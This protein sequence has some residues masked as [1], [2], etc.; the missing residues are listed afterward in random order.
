[1]PAAA[2]RPRTRRLQPPLQVPTPPARLPCCT[3][4]PCPHA[5]R[6]VILSREDLDFDGLLKLSISL[7]GH[8]D[9]L[10]LLELAD[11]LVGFA[12]EAGREATAG[13]P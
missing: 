10:P 5:C 7:G 4:R 3:A 6:R 1:M 8:L 9:M 12:G 13:L 11:V 2:R